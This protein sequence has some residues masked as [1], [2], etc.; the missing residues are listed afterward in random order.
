M[1]GFAR[2]PA[3]QFQRTK[4]APDGAPSISRIANRQGWMSLLPMTRFGME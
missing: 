2:N 3:T 4:G 1:A